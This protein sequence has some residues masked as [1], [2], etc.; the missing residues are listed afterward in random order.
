[1]PA[2]YFGEEASKAR[3]NF[4]RE[5]RNSTQ[6]KIATLKIL[7]IF[8]RAINTSHPVISSISLEYRLKHWCKLILPPEI[9]A[10]LSLPQ[11]LIALPISAINVA[12]SS[13]DED[14][15]ESDKETGPLEYLE[16]TSE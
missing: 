12:A 15:D 4:I 10:M 1:M 9:I 14:E 13:E 16:L 3:I 11:V 7:K 5:I 6:G 8:N 2:G